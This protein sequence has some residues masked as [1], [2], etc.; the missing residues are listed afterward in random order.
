VPVTVNDDDEVETVLMELE[1]SFLLA[2]GVMYNKK[3]K[4]LIDEVYA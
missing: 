2:I 3:L 4:Q 1:V